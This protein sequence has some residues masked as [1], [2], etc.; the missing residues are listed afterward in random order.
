LLGAVCFGWNFLCT[1]IDPESFKLCVQNVKANALESRIDCI[2][3]KED[4]LLTFIFERKCSNKFA[5]CVCNPP[6][7]DQD[8]SLK[9]RCTM[10]ESEAIAPD[11][12]Y[13]FAMRIFKESQLL[14]DKISWYTCMIGKKDTLKRLVSAFYDSDTPPLVVRKGEFLQGKQT[15][16]TVA[17][18]FDPAIKKVIEELLDK[19]T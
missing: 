13:G 9:A 8:S 16:W 17:W 15:R 1:E 4:S 18:S 14:G 6:F 2:M 12:E 7:F 3:G 10:T 19:V 11:G 5:A